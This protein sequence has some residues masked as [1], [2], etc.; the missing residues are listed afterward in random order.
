MKICYQEYK[1]VSN[2]KTA[3]KV[4]K[5]V[6]GKGLSRVD[7]FIENDTNKVYLNEINTMPG[8]TQISMYPKLMEAYGIQYKKIL[9]DLIKLAKE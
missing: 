9:D 6:D 7:F 1:T 5:A 8:F 3:I 4:F 2:R